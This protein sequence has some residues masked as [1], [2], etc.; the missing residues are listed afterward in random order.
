MGEF[1]DE[2][3][4]ELDEIRELKQ[5]LKEELD[6]LRRERDE[7]R[8][9]RPRE[10]PPHREPPP[11][12]AAV[13]DLS[14]ITEGLDEMMA[15]I[16]E[17]IR[18]SVEGL[19]RCGRRIHGP[20]IRFSRDSRERRRAIEQISPERVARVISPL[21]S[22]ERL[23]ILESLK[24]GGKT[25]NE[26]EEQTGRTGSSLTH[27]LNPL[28]EA[29]YVIKGEV[30]GTYYLSVEG[31]LAYRLAQWL[32]SKVERERRSNGNHDETEH[33]EAPSDPEEFDSGTETESRDTEVVEEPEHTEHEDEWGGN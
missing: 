6:S 27:H 11:P 25:F 33:A 13:I 16:G 28:L 8:R 19:D 23:R 2:I 14:G 3:R 5:R 4:R 12:R 26:L 20:F 10:R 7:F 24:D 9:H 1:R 22:E 32:T 31:R 18:M 17:Q 29:G 21:G 30:R 15:G